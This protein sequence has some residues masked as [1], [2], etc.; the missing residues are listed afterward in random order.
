LGIAQAFY[1]GSATVLGDLDGAK[2]WIEK[3]IRSF[4]ASDMPLYAAAAHH[5]RGELLGGEEGKAELGR[6]AAWMREH[7]GQQLEQLSAILV[8]D[9]RSLT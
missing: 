2:T 3:S 4:E 8:P 7:G 6:A 5:R 1:A 9:L